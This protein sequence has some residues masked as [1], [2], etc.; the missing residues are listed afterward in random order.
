MNFECTQFTKTHIPKT[1][2]QKVS[3]SVF[4]GAGNRK[5]GAIVCLL[6]FDLKKKTKCFMKNSEFSAQ[7]FFL[8]VSVRPNYCIQVMRI[9]RFTAK[10]Y[11]LNEA[12]IFAWNNYCFWIWSGGKVTK[13]KLTFKK[14]HFFLFEYCEW[15]RGLHNVFQSIWLFHTVKSEF[16]FL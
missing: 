16:Q 14:V 12:E 15:Q 2:R 4:S 11:N 6:Q 13:I 10:N 3:Q 5:S 7:F 9:R 8:S 1:E